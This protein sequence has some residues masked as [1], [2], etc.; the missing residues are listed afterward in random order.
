MFYYT[1]LCKLFSQKRTVS[2]GIMNSL[3]DWHKQQHLK[4][5]RPKTPANTSDVALYSLMI[6]QL[7]YVLK[8]NENCIPPPGNRY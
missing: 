4:V 7:K 5:E 1:Q 6:K 8:V 3:T 2:A